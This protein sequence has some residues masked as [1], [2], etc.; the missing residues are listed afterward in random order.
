MAIY[1]IN[2]NAIKRDIS[3]RKGD[4]MF[5]KITV[6]EANYKNILEKIQNITNKWRMLEGYYVFKGDLKNED[7][8]YRRFSINLER[9]IIYNKGKNSL[10]KKWKINKYNIFI[11]ATEH[12]I[13]IEY[14]SDPES[15][16]GKMYL[17]GKPLIHMSTGACNANVLSVG[18][19]IKFLPFGVFIVYT[20][21]SHIRFEKE[22]PLTIYKNVYIP[23]IFYRIK[24]LSNEIAIRDK[25]A[26]EEEEYWNKE[27]ERNME[28]LIEDDG[29]EDDDE[30]Y[31]Y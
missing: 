20:D 9:N 26:E 24:N 30:S 13:K 5:K 27:Y 25:E 14:D 15:F 23:D 6:T 28:S 10:R 19:K 21:D 12:W 2:L 1:L 31:D 22:D 29:W 17:N 18:D 11:N 16:H 8:Q 7:K 3:N 4:C